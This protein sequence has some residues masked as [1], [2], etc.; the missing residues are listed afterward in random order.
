MR[1]KD[2][3][4]YSADGGFPGIL[5]FPDLERPAPAIIFN[6]GY[7]AYM[8]M[9]DEMAEAFCQAGYVTLQYDMRGMRG[10]QSGR[11]LC[12][13]QWLE[14]AS[15]C[16]S[17]VMGLP[18]V[19]HERIGLAG[20]SMGGA[21]TIRQGAVDPRVKCLYAMAPVG[22]WGRIMEEKWVQNRGE[23][24]W[25]SFV[26]E[27]YDDAARIAQG[28]PSRKVNGG[29]GGG[30]ICSD[31]EADARELAE[32]PFK[33]IDLPLESVF[34]TYL[35]VD[36]VRAARSVQIPLCIVHGTADEVVPPKWA[37][38]IYSAA[39]AEHKKLHFIEGAG[40]VLPEEACEVCSRIGIEW[41]DRWLKN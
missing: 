39:A 38:E 29:Y 14:D 25:K 19:D 20:V 15:S 37:E 13:T 9:Y 22:N 24:A 30:G 4:I 34:N 17:Y 6:N 10:S 1:I 2:I 28:F 5:R 26:Q 7:C 11:F 16:I 32:H 33:V 36:S 35:Y 18:E 21:T 8:E 40:H 41:F 27:M 31:P 3:M 12:G 23:E